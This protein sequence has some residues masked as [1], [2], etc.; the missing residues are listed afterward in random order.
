MKR[1]LMLIALVSI[2]ILTGL[3]SLKSEE[4]KIIGFGR[5]EFNFNNPTA[6]ILSQDGKLCLSDTD[7]NCIKVFDKEGT[8]LFSFGAEGNGDGYFKKPQGIAVSKDGKIFVSDTDNK[9]IAVFDKEV[10]VHCKDNKSW[11]IRFWSSLRNDF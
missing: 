10:G 11:H 1:Y 2:F 6:L 4:V 9:R 3:P 5:R 8:F 7:N